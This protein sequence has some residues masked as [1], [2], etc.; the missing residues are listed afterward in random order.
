LLSGIAEDD[1]WK[2]RSNHPVKL[3]AA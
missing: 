3:F 2:F 1:Q